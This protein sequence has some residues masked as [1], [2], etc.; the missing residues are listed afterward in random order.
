MRVQ[1]SIKTVD[2]ALSAA[3]QRQHLTGLTV[4]DHTGGLQ[5]IWRQLA[6]ALDVIELL[7]D[8]LLRIFLQA[9]I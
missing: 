5:T 6:L 8:R 9:W 7:T 3:Y 1:R 4:G 2:M